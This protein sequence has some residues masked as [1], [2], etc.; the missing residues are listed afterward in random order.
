MPLKPITGAS[1]LV[2]QNEKI[3]LIKR[4]KAPY[5]GHWSLPG[6]SQE[7]GE[8]LEEAARRELKEET[9]LTASNLSFAKVR[10]RITLDEEGNVKFHFVLAT[11]ITNDVKGEPM[12]LD[13]ADDIGWYT[14]A[15]MENILTTPQTPEFIA[16]LLQTHI[17]P[18]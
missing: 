18:S 17:K 3:L 16:E 4:G 6:G 14:I 12:A 5:M 15:E 2:Y 7:L 8:T 9:N 1:V 13:D 11:F 10:D